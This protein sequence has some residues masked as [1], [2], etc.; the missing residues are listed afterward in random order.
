M[1][2][3]DREDDGI[4]KKVTSSGQSLREQSIMDVYIAQSGPWS[5]KLSMY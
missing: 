3:A 4:S 5:I 1:G 2:R